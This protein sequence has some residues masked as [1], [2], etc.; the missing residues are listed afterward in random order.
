MARAGVVDPLV[1]QKL[2]AANF[3]KNQLTAGTPE[4]PTREVL[5]LS[6]QEVQTQ[7]LISRFVDSS[8]P[9]RGEA[10]D[11]LSQML[12]R[13]SDITQLP[14]FKSIL[15]VVNR[16]TDDRVNSAI[17][18]T[19]LQGMD[20][21]G[22]QGSA[23]GRELAAGRTAQV[24]ALAP[25]A[26]SE[27]NRK[28]QISQL[29]DQ[30]LQSGDQDALERIGLSQAGGEMTRG[31]GQAQSDAEFDSIMRRLL[32]PSTTGADVASRIFGGDVDTVVTPSGP[33]K[34]AQTASILA[35]IFG[36][37]AQNPNLFN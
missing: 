6:P 18:R 30:L 2:S 1:H 22:A 5:G 35:A 14:E 26:E 19:K 25:F 28:L 12:N 36:G 10:I 34:S 21:S 23:V 3:L 37:A 4:L 16:D 32:F 20:T 11:V 7:G 9:Q 24:A 13:D 31:I 33:G 27:R 8:S 15:D 17:R 29:M